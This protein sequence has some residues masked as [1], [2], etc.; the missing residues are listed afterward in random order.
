MEGIGVS[1]Q[2]VASPQKQRRGEHRDV[3]LRQPHSH[4]TPLGKRDVVSVV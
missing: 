3:Q 1:G 2:P 4:H